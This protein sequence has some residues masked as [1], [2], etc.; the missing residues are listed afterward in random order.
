MG[1]VSIKL[2][3]STLSSQRVTPLANSLNLSYEISIHTLLAESDKGRLFIYELLKSI[4]IHTLLAESDP[5][6]AANSPARLDFNPHSPRR[7]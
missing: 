5:N 1:K 6:I 4:S 3:Q 2:F 7:E